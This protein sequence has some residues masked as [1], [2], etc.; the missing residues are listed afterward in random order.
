MS[1]D[2]SAPGI[3]TMLR[4]AVSYLYPYRVRFSSGVSLTLLGI[5]L[6]LVKPLPLALVL[7]VVLGHEALPSWLTPA[8]G[9]LGEVALLSWAALAIVIVTFAR[10]AVTLASNYLTIHTGQ[11][12][13]ND[14]RT[15]LYAHL[16]KLSL[17]FH[18]RQ[19]TGD[20]LFR[21]MADTFSAQGM[22]MNGFLPL[23][24]AAV[25]LVG[26]FAVMAR[27]DWQL[28]LIALIVCPPLF[29][30]VNR[31][32][33]HI[34]KHASASR[35][36]ESALYAR[37]ET[38][39][40]AVKLM[41]AYGREERAVAEFREGSERSLALSLRLYSVETFFGLVVD[42]VLALGTAALVWVGAMHVMQGRL[43]IGDLTIFLSYLKDLYAPIQNISA[44]LAEISSSRA[45][46]ERVFA[47]LDIR[48]DITDA[49]GARDLPA[50]R[51]KVHFED[52]TFAYEDGHP[53]LRRIDLTIQPG[54]RVALVGRTG[55]GKS[56]L[57]SLILRF[58]DPQEGRVTLDGQDLRDVTL[59]SLRSQV[60][61]MLQEPI[62]FHTS[63]VENLTLGAPMRSDLVRE[64]ARRAEAE[65]F[66]VALPQGYETVI[67]EHGATL[68]GGQRQRLALARALLREAP[69]VILDEPTS[70]LDV[71]TEG[72]VWRNVET[73]LEG[74][75][76]IVIAHRLTT[77]RRADRIVVLEQGQIVEQGS[78]DELL[79]RN[80]AYADMWRRGGQEGD[81]RVVPFPTVAGA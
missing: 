65:E 53:V 32:G 12:M 63:V 33:G 10:G 6:D 28:S 5:A 29:I 4:R 67:G 48:P 61:L 40:G 35:E 20:L 13:V 31:I 41:Q 39:I 23:C 70:S 55:A 68:S 16:Q 80:G 9:G 66:I 17:K 43:N 36:A 25:M 44:N 21:V 77:A 79:A 11:C 49:P 30:A 78:H 50:A 19:Q 74:R 3:T 54:E 71:K 37:A 51:G 69:V 47:V 38:T 27:Y 62:L 73:L 56:T 76:A 18:N 46:L 81:D 64:A 75:T 42:C 59:R 52:V 60:T 58:F 45:G 14:L 2:A 57:A 15:E 8:L 7:D 24:S 26:M 34:H 22:V 72:Q 1:I